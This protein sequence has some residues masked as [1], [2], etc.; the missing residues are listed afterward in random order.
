M[1]D[2]ILKYAPPILA[3]IYNIPTKKLATQNTEYH[4]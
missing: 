1:V 4:V 3:N 2:I